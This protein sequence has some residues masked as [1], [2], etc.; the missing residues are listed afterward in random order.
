MLK[1]K[2]LGTSLVD[3]WLRVHASK[4]GACVQLVSHRLCC[5]ARK[6]KKKS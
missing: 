1:K 6:K 4:Q 2:K 5:M 3:Q